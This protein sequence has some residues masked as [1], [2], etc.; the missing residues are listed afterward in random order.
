MSCDVT[1]DGE[2]YVAVAGSVEGSEFVMTEVLVD[3]EY[4]CNNLDLL[5]ERLKWMALLLRVS[6]R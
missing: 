1:S 6:R 3:A 2:W 4:S 5:S